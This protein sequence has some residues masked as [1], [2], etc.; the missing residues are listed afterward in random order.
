MFPHVTDFARAHWS[1]SLMPS[2]IEQP[3]MQAV[4]HKNS[5]VIQIEFLSN[6]VT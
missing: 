5:C 1:K 6:I 4:I 3:A 2:S